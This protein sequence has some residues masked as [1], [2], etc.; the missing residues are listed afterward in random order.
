MVTLG[1]AAVFPSLILLDVLEPFTGGAAGKQVDFDLVP[2]DWLPLDGISDF[3]HSLPVIGGF[4]EEGGLSDREEERV[5][6]FILMTGIALI[7]F[8]LVSNLIKSRPGRAM[9]AIR[10]NETSAAVNGISLSY[11]KTM[12]FGVASALGGVCLLYTSPS[13][14]D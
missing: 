3:L 2:P 9:R 4:F 6:R 12:S 7:C 8:K 14:R 5:W 1:L 11:Y 10:D 13:P